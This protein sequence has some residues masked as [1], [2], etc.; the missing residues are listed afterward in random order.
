MTPGEID[1]DMREAVSERVAA[2]VE[3]ARA[4]RARARAYRTAKA[5][6][7]DA[8]LRQRHRR[9]ISRQESAT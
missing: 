5:R 4:R 1:R 8:G 6:R 2:R 3:E 7:R 9:K